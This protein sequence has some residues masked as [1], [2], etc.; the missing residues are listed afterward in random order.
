MELLHVSQGSSIPPTSSY[1]S[2]IL[3]RVRLQPL[4]TI[5]LGVIYP[6]CDFPASTSGCGELLPA[7]TIHPQSTTICDYHQL[8]D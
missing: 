4:H 2:Q 7:P 5:P 6:A 8:I 3:A 1:I